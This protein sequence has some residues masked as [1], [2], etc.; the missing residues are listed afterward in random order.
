MILVFGFKT[1][2]RQEVGTLLYAG[3]DGDEAQKA[4]EDNTDL[5]PRIMRSLPG[6]EAHF[7]T[8]QHFDENHPALKAAEKS[9]E[10]FQDPENI[11][12]TPNDPE[13]EVTP[14]PKAKRSRK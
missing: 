1:P 4:F 2:S 5:Y 10:T 12:E 9:A 7:L 13:P 6:V 14:E 8:V 3:N 11:S